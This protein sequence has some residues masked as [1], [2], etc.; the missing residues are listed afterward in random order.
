[1]TTA[2]IHIRPA[3]PADVATIASFNIAM[4]WETEKLRLD[5]YTLEHG[6]QAVLADGAKGHYFVAEIAG[7]VAGCLMVTHEW[8]DWRNGDI[9]WIQSVFV[10]PSHRRKGVFAAMYRHVVSHAR[11]K[12]VV[13]IRLYV[14]H[15]N[16]A[17]K[18]TY[19]KLGMSG[20]HYDVMQQ[21]L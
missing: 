21:D 15:D 17:G 4:A 20:T 7:A 12:G 18:A 10:S 6:V 2:A 14:E 11:E 8:S 5:A 9:W 1:M 3:K 13:A 16:A 19:L